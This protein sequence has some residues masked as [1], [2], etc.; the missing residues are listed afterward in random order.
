MSDYFQQEVDN[1]S[2][3]SSYH[4]TKKVALFHY[5][6]GSRQNPYELRR[7]KVDLDESTR[8]YQ[9][10][11]QRINQN[12]INQEN[13]SEI[14]RKVMQEYIRHLDRNNTFLSLIVKGF[15]QLGTDICSGNLRIIPD[16]EKCILTESF[17]ID[18]QAIS[19]EI[20]RKAAEI[21]TSV[22]IDDQHNRKFFQEIYNGS[23]INN[24]W[25][26]AFEYAR[27]ELFGKL[28]QVDECFEEKKRKWSLISSIQGILV[29]LFAVN[30]EVDDSNLSCTFSIIKNGPASYSEDSEMMISIMSPPLSDE[31][32]KLWERE[33]FHQ[34]AN[35]SFESIQQ[36][37]RTMEDFNIDKLKACL[38]IDEDPDDQMTK[39]L[40]ES[41]Q[42]DVYYSSQDVNT[43]ESK[44]SIL[45]TNYLINKRHEGKPLDFFIVCGELSQFKDSPQIRFRDLSSDDKQELKWHKD[46]KEQAVKVANR[47]ANEHYPW[48]ES[49]RYALFWNTAAHVNDNAPIGLVCIE[50][51]NW[52]NIVQA[53]F[54]DHLPVE[55]PNCIICYVY[56]NPQK[57]GVQ[58][59][60]D[61]QVKELLQW[62]NNKWKIITSESRQNTLKN[63]LSKLLPPHENL[64]TILKVIIQI[65]EDPTKGG[66]IV[67]VEN[68]QATDAFKKLKKNMGKPWNLEDITSEDVIALVSQ[69]GATLCP[70]NATNLQTLQYRKLL[71]SSDSSLNLL[72]EIEERW[73]SIRVNQDYEWPLTAKGSRRWNA[74][75]AACHEFVHTVLVISQDGD[76]QVWHIRNR[77]VENTGKPLS[78]IECLEI[79]EFP[80]QGAH[81]QLAQISE[82]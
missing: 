49:G 28:I 2:I 5:L 72:N 56:S 75:I 14:H 81:R 59:V 74:A 26:T 27:Y 54:R 6:R 29:F 20:S 25:K 8:L 44:W 17:T 10:G 24:E 76:I 61:K 19:W 79:H 67:F 68:D 31:K 40:I 39:Y 3:S 62:Q 45:L 82:D 21:L 52:I 42:K 50:H 80:L 77:R 13:Q 55:L 46:G 16:N 36:K 32:L 78:A 7:T 15:T 18:S 66:T 53:R 34:Q 71:L 60:K 43:D 58:L 33:Y 22:Y 41:I 64:D 30:D 48:F 38:G 51:F 9:L 35:N 12:A 37:A 69:D 4:S 57:V 73:S 47:I 11:E 70:I 23:K 63:V 65:S 1:L